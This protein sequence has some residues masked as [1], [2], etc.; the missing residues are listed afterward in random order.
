MRCFKEKKDKA[1]KYIKPTKPKE[2][3]CFFRF[4]IGCKRE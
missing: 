3:S 2:I 1:L 4:F